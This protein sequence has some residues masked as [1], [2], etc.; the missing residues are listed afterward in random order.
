MKKSSVIKLVSILLSAILILS[1]GIIWGLWAKRAGDIKQAYITDKY[2]DSV[3]DPNFNQD[4]IKLFKINHY[5]GNYSGSIAV[6]IR[7]NRSPAMISYGVRVAGIYFDYGFSVE[8][9][10][11][12]KAGRIY[13]LSEAYELGLLNQKDVE[14]L[15]EKYYA[16]YPHLTPNN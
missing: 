12:Y 8:E 4:V 3:N 10:T 9:I 15:S 14:K 7:G 11:I 5:L 6:M 13:Y 1:L 2:G 16:L